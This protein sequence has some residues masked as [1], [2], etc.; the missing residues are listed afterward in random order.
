MKKNSAASV[1]HI[2]M[3]QEELAKR[4]REAREHEG[5]SQEEVAKKLDIPRASVSMLENAQRKVD[6]LE[7]VKLAKIYGKSPSHFLGGETKPDNNEATLLFRSAA[8]Q[9]PTNTIEE[10]KEFSENYLW[11]SR[12][13][14]GALTRQTPSY[15][16]KRESRENAK[17]LATEIREKLELG[18]APIPEIFS[19]LELLGLHV[20]R[21]PIADEVSGIFL[22]Q[23]E[24]GA[25]VLINSFRTKG[26]Q[27]FTAAHEL[28]HFLKDRFAIE[29][30]SC[31]IGAVNPEL[32]EIFANYFAAEFLMP[33]EGIAEWM[34]A[35]HIRKEDLDAFVIIHLQ[36]WFR[37]SYRAMLV[38]LKQLGHISGKAF[39]TLK[40]ESANR[41]D[42]QLGYE[43]DEA[44]VNPPAI[45]PHQY[46]QLAFEAYH[47]GK[48][49]IGRLGE[50]LETPVWKIQA[51][52][53]EKSKKESI[54]EER[55]EAIT[56]E[57]SR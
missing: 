31:D 41:I 13:M 53:K 17:R 15:P 27:V 2:V 32:K 12:L 34:Q 28:C 11:L 47:A 30:I 51:I 8:L 26:H 21:K 50:L 38:R 37:V 46:R 25:F 23:R 1:E 6:S 52:L 56:L 5:L 42:R 43:P 7:L 4:L 19:I 29:G 18:Y 40:V 39:E 10:F 33:E 57:R 3:T 45:F 44:P 36:Q 22:H 35:N 55:H 24:V 20:L 54:A 49:S 9:V 48:I 14:G 16:I